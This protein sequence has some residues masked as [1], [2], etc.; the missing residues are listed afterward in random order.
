MARKAQKY[1]VTAQYR[2]WFNTADPR[3]NK[4]RFQ[5]LTYVEVEAVSVKQAWFLAFKKL[6]KKLFYNYNLCVSEE[7]DEDHFLFLSNM[8]RG[9]CAADLNRVSLH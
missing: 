6:P 5:P 1:T 4:L 3:A 8:E 7:F 9:A 2:K